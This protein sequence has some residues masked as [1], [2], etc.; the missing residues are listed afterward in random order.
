MA[1]ALLAAYCL[2]KQYC[3]K[4][5]H[6]R[7]EPV[8]DETKDR[9]FRVTYPVPVFRSGTII[10]MA[11]RKFDRHPH[12]EA[13]IEKINEYLIRNHYE[14]SINAREMPVIE[15]DWKEVDE[16]RVSDQEIRIIHE[17]RGF[18]KKFSQYSMMMYVY[19]D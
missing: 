18:L 16:D 13:I 6:L 19:L 9:H 12:K 8:K 10:E 15:F 11:T 14:E 3:F 17:A 4:T 2:V 5:E 1:F 7:D